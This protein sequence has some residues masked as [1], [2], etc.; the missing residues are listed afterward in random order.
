MST[1]TTNYGLVKPELT[2]AADITAMNAN[3]DLIDEELSNI[4]TIVEEELGSLTPEK[5]GAVPLSRVVYGLTT[6]VKDYAM[7]LERGFYAVHFT[8][9]TYEGT[10]LPDGNYKYGAAIIYVRIKSDVI[11]IMLLGTD[12]LPPQ[13]AHCNEGVWGEWSTQFLP[14]TGGKI[15]GNLDF[16]KVDNGSATVYKNHS[17]TADY[18]LIIRDVDVDGNYN[19]LLLCAKENTLKYRDTSGTTSALYGGHNKPT[20]AD[21]AAGT[22]SSTGIKAKTGTDYTTARIRNIKASTTN[23]T[24]GTSAL[25]SGDIYLVYE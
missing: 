10:D 24:A 5:I 19:Q 1:T 6:N 20:A 9:N 17:E 21:I 13:F 22:F 12:T 2:D 16:K 25:T 23:L 4:G 11:T 7:T 15:T 18:G 3:W 8:G 14:L